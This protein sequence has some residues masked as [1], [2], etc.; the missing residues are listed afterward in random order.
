MEIAMR[1]ALRT[2][3]F[4]NIS[5]HLA[6]ITGRMIH[7][8]VALVAAPDCMVMLHKGPWLLLRENEV[9]EQIS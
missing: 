4:H 8:H 7:R 3:V 5:L 2:N 6:R 9:V 1:F